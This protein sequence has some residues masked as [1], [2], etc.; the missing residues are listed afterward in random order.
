MDCGELGNLKLL[1]P[2]PDGK[3]RQGRDSVSGKRP[4]LVPEVYVL[5]VRIGSLTQLCRLHLNTRL[6][7]Q[8]A[9]RC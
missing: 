7:P 6:C 4:W 1:H 8:S 3:F 9:F 2:P 5:D